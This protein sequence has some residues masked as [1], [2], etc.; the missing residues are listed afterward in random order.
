MKS[1]PARGSRL[2]TRLGAEPIVDAICEIRFD[3]E[4]PTLPDLLPGLLLDRFGSV[5]EV[6]RYQGTG[7][8]SKV[9]P[10]LRVKLA[11]GVVLVGPQMISF[12]ISGAYPGWRAFRARAWHVFSLAKSK[13]LVGS[14]ARASVRYI[15]LIPNLG[16][17]TLNV[18]IAFGSQHEFEAM[19]AKV[20]QEIDGVHAVTSVGSPAE[21]S[22]GRIGVVVDIDTMLFS[23]ADFWGSAERELDRLH[24]INKQLF[25]N[26]L[27]DSTVA[28]L[29]PEYEE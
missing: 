11:D 19:E 17:S 3:D 1:K 27:S 14:V 7:D 2:P 20:A 29:E 26:V 22:D 28:A 15:D 6:A 18:K 9:L 12:S 24:A 8:G 25:F 21:L 10:R 4:I 13:G 5:D 16:R 23:P